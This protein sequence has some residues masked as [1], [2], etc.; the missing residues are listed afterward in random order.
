MTA[1]VRCDRTS[2]WRSLS[3]HF[4]THARD[5][6]LRDAFAADPDR[7]HT[8]TFE[9]PDVFADL[10]KNRLDETTVALLVALARECGLETRRDAMLA[11]APVNV[12]EGRSVQ[13]TA[14]RAPRKASAQGD[15]IHDVLERMLDFAE[16][17]RDTS[18]SGIQIGRAHV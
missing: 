6:D 16:R 5:F 8:F 10:S 7:F 1:P 3:E 18:A 11:G 17:I 2:A 15:A 4:D 9:A 13:H 14:L 12:T